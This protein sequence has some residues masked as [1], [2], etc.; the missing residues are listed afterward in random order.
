MADLM[1]SAVAW[2]IV[3]TNLNILKP[4]INRLVGDYETSNDL[5]QTYITQIRS[6][7]ST[8]NKM[9]RNHVD[10]GVRCYVSN[11]QLNRILAFYR[12]TILV[13]KEAAEVYTSTAAF[14]LGWINSIVDKYLIEYSAVRPKTKSFSV[15]IPAFGEIN[16]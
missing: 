15:E 10:N 14:N 16:W 6:V 8:Q 2:K 9:H 11:A 12:S 1:N 13:I 4:A 5:M 3:L 7:I